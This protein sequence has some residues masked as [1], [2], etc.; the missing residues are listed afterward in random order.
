MTRSWKSIQLQN[1][2]R[3]FDLEL[4]QN[5]AVPAYPIGSFWLREDSECIRQNLTA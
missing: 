2:S 5:T 4:A 3:T 1:K